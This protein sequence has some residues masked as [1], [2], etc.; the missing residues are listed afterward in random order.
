ACGTGPGLGYLA[1]KARSLQAGDITAALVTRCNEIYR[2]RLTV[3]IMDAAHLPQADRSLDV[4]L[5]LEAIYYLLDVQTFIAE[6]RRVLRPG[7][8][9]LIATAN[10]DLTDFNPSPYS[11]KYFGTVELAQVMRRQGFQPSLF[12]YGD[13]TRAPLR[14]RLLRP[15]KRIAVATR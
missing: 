1:C 9:V 10:K 8:H 3:S 14:E 15:A 4:V 2:G 7:G 11:I 13:I 6:C 5:L 12:G